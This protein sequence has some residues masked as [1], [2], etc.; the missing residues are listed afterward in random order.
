[1][2]L[3][4][5]YLHDERY[6]KPLQDPATERR[7]G[8]GLFWPGARE[9]LRHD[10]EATGAT[11]SAVLPQGNE[12][13]IAGLFVSAPLTRQQKRH[14]LDR[15]SESNQF[16][17][18]EFL[19]LCLPDPVL[20]LPPPPL[21]FLARYTEQL[22]PALTEPAPFRLKLWTRQC[23]RMREFA[24]RLGMPVLELP[25]SVFSPAGFLA[26][27]CY[28]NDPTHANE[29]Y[30][31]R[32]LTALLE[33]SRHAAK[34]K[35]RAGSTHPYTTLPDHCFWKKAV[36]GSDPATFDPVTKPPFLIGPTTRIAAAGSC[37]AQHISHHLRAGGY[38]FMDMEPMNGGG[39]DEGQLFSARYGNIY[40]AR[41]L[42]QLFERA[43][44]DFVPVTR[45]WSRPDGRFCDPFRPNVEPDGFATDEDVIE[46]QQEHL[47]AVRRMFEQLDLFI[48]TLGLTECWVA[49]Q[50]GAAYPL[51]P[52]V[53]GGQYDPAQH[54]FVNFS[55]AEVVA[56]L[57]RFV[58]ALRNVNPEARL[59]LT[60]SPVA[61]AATAEDRH[62]LVSTTYSKAVLRVAAE[63]IVRKHQG[64]YY[65]P[66]YEI[67]T[68]PQ[69]E[70]RYF[71]ADKRSVS[72]KGVKHVMGVF[73]SRLTMG[74]GMDDSVADAMRD[75]QAKVEIFCDEELLSR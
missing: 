13:N 65:F 4:E 68:G 53:A 57:D 73:M 19:V 67:I 25:A 16:D 20:L 2:E 41:Q 50:D 12:H 54:A 5:I 49:R 34:R 36:A 46:A 64:I 1:V 33:R 60:V 28:G 18:L 35:R 47:R 14:W 27:D 62:V 63:E 9:L 24:D 23:D 45:A 39:A 3:A 44:C 37:F 69:A 52:G 48:F 51:A 66:S 31:E 72:D 21:E 59:I 15:T 42:V 70:G 32:V 29:V 61:L 10:I 43:F 8:S 6:Q 17:W 38:R 40:T 55:V 74:R 30:G 22:D 7:I 58:V 56:D 71:A 26:E 11:H 75:A